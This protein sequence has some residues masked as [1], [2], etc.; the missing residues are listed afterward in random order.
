MPQ[1]RNVNNRTERCRLMRIWI[2]FPRI[3]GWTVE[4]RAMTMAT[5]ATDYASALKTT[6]SHP[7]HSSPNGHVKPSSRQQHLCQRRQ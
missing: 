3:T 5:A 1:R 6:Q 2:P 7:S 4:D